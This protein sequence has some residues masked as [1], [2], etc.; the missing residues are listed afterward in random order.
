MQ[1]T[2]SSLPSVLRNRERRDGAIAFHPLAEQEFD[3]GG[4][5]HG[6]DVSFFGTAKCHLFDDNR[7]VQLF[8]PDLAI[9]VVSK[10]DTFEGL[11]VKA[12]RYRQCGTQEVWILSPATREALVQSE[13]GRAYLSDDQMFESKLI[14][15]F[16]IL[17]ADLFNRK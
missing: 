16:G 13:E 4:N 8:V 5:A 15:G 11:T 7:R 2:L 12:A 10:N 1:V 3:F 9:E 14:P 17:L 6:P